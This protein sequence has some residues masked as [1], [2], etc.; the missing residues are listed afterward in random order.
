ML[1]SK[2]SVA[3]WGDLRAPF[4]HLEG[5]GV[6]FPSVCELISII[7]N[8]VESWAGD[9]GDGVHAEAVTHLGGGI[10]FWSE[11]DVEYLLFIGFTGD[12]ANLDLEDEESGG[13]G[14]RSESRNASD[15][16]WVELTDGM[17][18]GE[19]MMSGRVGFN[20]VLGDK[21]DEGGTRFKDL[22]CCGVE[23][24]VHDFGV[25]V[26]VVNGMTSEEYSIFWLCLGTIRND[27]ELAAIAVEWCVPRS[28]VF[29]E[30]ELSDLGK[31][32][33]LLIWDKDDVE[34]V[35][36]YPP[37]S[38]WRERD[39]SLFRTNANLQEKNRHAYNVN[40]IL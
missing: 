40:N 35:M 39:E 11:C 2:E 22:F 36:E 17:L 10:D 28:L 30:G 23:D 14:L 25:S 21:G 19:E 20:P 13:L 9:D 34:D 1:N 26:S 32:E 12:E 15:W 8:L 6:L 5:G 4:N 29:N 18:A 7:G 16:L 38:F 3:V 37:T 33:P 27:S 24:C 31:G